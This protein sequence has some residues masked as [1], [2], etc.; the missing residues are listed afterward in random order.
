MKTKRNSFNGERLLISYP[1]CGDPN[2]SMVG[3]I[4]P[5]PMANRILVLFEVKGV[6]FA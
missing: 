5:L 1:R 4:D 6:A 2:R 3:S